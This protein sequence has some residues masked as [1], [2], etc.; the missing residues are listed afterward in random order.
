MTA[1]QQFAEQ[2][3]VDTNGDDAGEP[4]WLGELSG[5]D[6]VRDRETTLRASPYIASILGVKDA[7]GM[8]Q[9]SGYYYCLFLRGADGTWVAEPLKLSDAPPISA[10]QEWI[11]YAWPNTAG[12]SGNRV[13]V[14][15]WLGEVWAGA[16][17]AIEDGEQ[18]P[19]PYSGPDDTPHWDAA[20]NDA[21]T[22]IAD[23][24]KEH[25]GRDGRLWVPAR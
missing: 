23:G 4:G 15:T 20:F 24:A 17:T 22:A 9:K 18:P 11:C 16:N 12:Q 19:P 21:G 6:V 8:A 5:C 1:Q 13:F 14:A 10:S 3:E 2:R 7:K 25:R